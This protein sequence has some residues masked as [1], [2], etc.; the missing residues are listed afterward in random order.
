MT[1]YRITRSGPDEKLVYTCWRV[2]T[3]NNHRRATSEAFHYGLC[4]EE[5]RRI[6]DQDHKERKHGNARR[7]L[8]QRDA[9]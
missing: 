9:R 6:I 4:P 7:T 5:A 3:S 8:H 2:A 1:R